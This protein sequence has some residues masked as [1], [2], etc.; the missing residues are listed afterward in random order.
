MHFIES[1]PISAIDKERLPKSHA[2]KFFK[3]VNCY[4]KMS[5]KTLGKSQYI[6]E[7]HK[8]ELEKLGIRGRELK[9]IL[10]IKEM[11]Y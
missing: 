8:S 9:K 2:Q 10:E 1:L 3:I 4:F 11:S 7:K 6:K 5:Q